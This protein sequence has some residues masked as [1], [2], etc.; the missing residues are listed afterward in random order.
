MP[1]VQKRPG[2]DIAAAVFRG[3]EEGRRREEFK[4]LSKFRG[5]QMEAIL[6]DIK[7]G[8]ITR[9]K[10]ERIR[11]LRKE[12]LGGGD[13]ITAL[14]IADPDEARK[15]QAIRGEQ[16]KQLTESITRRWPLIKAMPDNLDKQKEL[17][18][19][20]AAVTRGGLLDEKGPGSGAAI[21]DHFENMIRAGQFREIEAIVDQALGGGKL[22]A[23]QR[24]INDT[25]SAHSNLSRTQAQDL[26]DDVVELRT[27]P[28][29]GQEQLVNKATGKI[30]ILGGGQ[31]PGQAPGQLAAT[32]QID[33]TGGID[34]IAEATGP[35]DV[36]AA[37]L[38]RVPILSELVQGG[39]ERQARTTFAILDKSIERA[40][41]NNRRFPEGEVKRL[42]ALLPTT[43]VFSTETAAFNDLIALKRG[44]NAIIQRERQDI[45]NV[46]L[47]PEIRKSAQA[48]VGDASMIVGQ[49]D[50]ILNAS[51][52]SYPVVTTQE[53][54][55]AIA[56]GGLYRGSDGKLRK[57]PK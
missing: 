21:A 53:Q 34:V 19:M 7:T 44:I 43:G 17:M 23:R 26:V 52:L 2:P 24:E 27:S 16:Q 12:A 35:L 55:N 38:E 57:K 5:L 13:A 51:N 48:T 37:I 8:E 28:V 49:I 15:V 32:P 40:F 4:E 18:T 33:I 50:Q 25:M 30:T 45:S 41:A 42:R 20:V 56:P 11:G 22:T 29:S 54:F 39:D 14:A 46:S 6:A 10:E 36:G 3:A 1:L 31:A 47:A 9:R